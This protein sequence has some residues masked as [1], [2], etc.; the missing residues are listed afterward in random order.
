MHPGPGCVTLGKWLPLSGLQ[1]HS[2]SIVHIGDPAL[3]PVPLRAEGTRAR[4]LEAPPAFQGVR[5][6]SLG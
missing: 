1:A 4:Y 3:A 2:S 6:P 5:S